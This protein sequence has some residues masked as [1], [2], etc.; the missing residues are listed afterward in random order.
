[1]RNFDEKTDKPIRAWIREQEAQVSFD[2]ET[3]IVSV[4]ALTPDGKEISTS[5]TPPLI[6]RYETNYKP[7]E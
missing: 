3:N 4:Y 7:A 6:I 1:M 5:D 2:P